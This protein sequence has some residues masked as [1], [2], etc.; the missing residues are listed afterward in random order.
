MQ[1]LKAVSFAKGLFASRQK[2]ETELLSQRST[3]KARARVHWDLEITDILQKH[4]NEI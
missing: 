1:C 3:V 4:Y 2:H